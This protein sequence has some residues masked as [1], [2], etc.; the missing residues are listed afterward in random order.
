MSTEI[1]KNP[2]KD[3]MQKPQVIAK[4]NEMLGKNSTNYITS[5]MQVVSSNSM[6]QNAEPSS[7]FHAT[8]MAAV[9]GFPINN[10]IG[11][12]FIVPY[13]ESYKDGNEWKK[14]TVA[15][16]QISAKGLTQLAIRSGEYQTIGE[17]PIFEGQL[18]SNNPLTGFVF[19]FSKPSNGKQIGHAAYFKLKNGFEKTIYMTTDELLAHG[20]KY[21][22]TFDNQ[23]ST[24]KTNQ[25]GMFAKTV[26]KR[27][28]SKYGPMSLEMQQSIEADQGVFDA[29]GNIH[30]PDNA[31][32]TPE[33]IIDINA[34]IV[35]DNNLN[36]EL[37]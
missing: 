15:Q 25:Q 20:K 33:S 18:I 14:R 30:Y 28:I 27:L 34:E 17:S 24:W 1:S 37:M 9:L 23:N 21:S 8:A 12:A 13:N 7:V 29:N 5:V 6:L 36:E 4:I 16:F 35:N 19:D 22:K 32:S 31:N 11:H 26:V 10:N 2:I 3:Y